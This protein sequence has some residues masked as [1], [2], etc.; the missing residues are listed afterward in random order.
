LIFLYIKKYPSYQTS[1]RRFQ[2]WIREG[3]LE[4]ILG[5]LAEECKRAENCSWRRPLSTP[6]APGQ[7][8]SLAVG[9]IKGGKETKIIALN[10]AQL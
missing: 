7:K 10:T 8:R 1:R 3:K 5:A 6:P 4:R 9:P 2:Q